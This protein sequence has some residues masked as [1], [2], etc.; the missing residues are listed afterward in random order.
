MYINDAASSRD[1]SGILLQVIPQSWNHLVISYNENTVDVFVNGNLDKSIP[2][3][4]K[5]RP[6]YNIGDI[7][8]VGEGDN[9]VTKGGL[10]G[11]I[12]NVV[13][14]KTPLTTFQVSR[15]YN[16]NRY[17]NPPVNS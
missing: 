15:D 11:A 3:E 1:I 5:V 12:C 14:Y 2:L 9:T 16:L 6:E 7:I 4:Q 17:K 13:Y 10:H 8:E